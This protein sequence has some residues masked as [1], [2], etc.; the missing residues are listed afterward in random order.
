MFYLLN[1]YALEKEYD[2]NPKKS[3][4]IVKNPWFEIILLTYFYFPFVFFNSNTYHIIKV[5]NVKFFIIQSKM[6]NKII[7]YT[8][9]P[10]I[11]FLILVFSPFRIGNF[12]LKHRTVFCAIVKLLW[13]F[14]DPS[15]YIIKLHDKASM[16]D[17]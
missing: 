1:V 7:N 4:E 10:H 6:S 17:S 16:S 14:M 9:N 12:K 8:F 5:K 2:F 3:I 13:L 15:N 11:A